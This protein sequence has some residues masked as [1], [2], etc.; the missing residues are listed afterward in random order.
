MPVTQVA[1]AQKARSAQLFMSRCLR[2]E[3]EALMRASE[4]INPI[5]ISPAL[6]VPATNTAA[7]IVP[8]KAT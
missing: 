7:E 3:A 4:T 6:A 1:L 5:D 8:N 2:L